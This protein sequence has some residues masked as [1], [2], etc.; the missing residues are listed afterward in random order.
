MPTMMAEPRTL[1]LVPVIRLETYQA[2]REGV[3]MHP[4][5][6]NVEPSV[7]TLL[8]LLWLSAFVLLGRHIAADLPFARSL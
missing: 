7:A 4:S 6:G 2:G 8:R 3:P 5:G 1:A